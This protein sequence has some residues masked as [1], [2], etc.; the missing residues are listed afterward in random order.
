VC[1]SLRLRLVEFGDK[2]EVLKAMA[3]RALDEANLSGGGEREQQ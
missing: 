1:Y 3:K 2:P